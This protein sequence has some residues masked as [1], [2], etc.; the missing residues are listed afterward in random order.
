MKRRERIVRL[1]Q[2]KG[3]E[4]VTMPREVH[5]KA[6]IYMEE[7]LRER[8]KDRDENNRLEAEM[9]EVQWGVGAQKVRH[10]A[11]LGVFGVVSAMVLGALAFPTYMWV[12]AQP[13]ENAFDS[14]VE[15][16]DEI[17]PDG[18][19]REDLQ[20]HYDNE[21]RC[22]LITAY[23]G[24][25]EFIENFSDPNRVEEIRTIQGE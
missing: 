17:E 15:V 23:Y 18:I 4:M 16:Y 7:L 14:C 6:L 10:T 13:F 3:P 11:H 5:L 21:G 8:T 24:E 1:L 22:Y 19:F 2:A 12:Q 9:R 25:K 20:R